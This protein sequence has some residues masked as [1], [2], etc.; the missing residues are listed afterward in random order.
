[1]IAVMG[2]KIL[3]SFSKERRAN[4]TD[5]FLKKLYVIWLFPLDLSRYFYC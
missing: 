4:F 1:M 2:Y 3:I 5:L